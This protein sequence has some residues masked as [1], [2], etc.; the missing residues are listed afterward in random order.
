MSVLTNGQGVG[1]YLA[2]QHDSALAQV[3]AIPPSSLERDRLEEL[4]SAIWEANR[5]ERLELLTDDLTALPAE[6]IKAATMSTHGVT[7]SRELLRV[8]RL[9]YSGEPEL[10]HKVPNGELNVP[11]IDDPLGPVI[12]GGP[13]HLLI[14]IRATRRTSQDI[15]NERV[16]II[17]WL[18]TKMAWL[19]EEVDIFN[20]RLRASVRERILERVELAE[21]AVELDAGSDVPIYRAPAQEQVPIPI[22][23]KS[24]RSA[25][26]RDG[27]DDGESHMGQE[28]YEDVVQTIEQMTLAMER[29]P[30]A[31]KLKEEEIRNLI[32][33]VLNA[34]YRGAAAGEVFNGDGKT[35]IL[36]RWGSD[37]AFIGECKMWKGPSEF[38][39]AI[40]QMLGYVTWR[41][42]KAALIV[43]IRSGNP[44]EIMEKAKATLRDH[45][46]FGSE[47][48]SG[49]HTRADF[50]LRSPKDRQRLISVA[51]IGVVLPNAATANS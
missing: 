19:N 25:P 27:R 29:T 30:T 3:D 38:S 32:L 41:D 15:T 28:I 1:A 5:V 49:S 4:T 2:E 10:W 34:N 6:P 40:D 31:A 11:G 18:H 22:E 36:L 37:N 26:G 35:D 51:L 48:P 23:R 24:L 33:F 17:E 46:A 50:V 20:H 47:A 13:D 45:S 21:Q 42:T 7:F 43:F 44:T 12:R 9:P 39:K 14:Q 16:K 8:F